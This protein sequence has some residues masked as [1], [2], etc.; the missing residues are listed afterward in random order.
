[1]LAAVGRR[2]ILT[3][4]AAERR[5]NMLEHIYMHG[6]ARD[7][8]KKK[9]ISFLCFL[10]FLILWTKNIRGRNLPLGNRVVVDENYFLQAIIRLL[11]CVACNVVR[12]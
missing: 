8:R 10:C 4:S 3:F 6:W 11:K 7:A 9:N 12:A 5:R 2:Q 1:M